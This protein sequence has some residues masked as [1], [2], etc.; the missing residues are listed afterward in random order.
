[1]DGNDAVYGSNGYMV[2]SLAGLTL[3]KSNA[4]GTVTETGTVGL[5]LGATGI[6]KDGNGAVWASAK[7]TTKNV[8]VL[9]GKQPNAAN[10]PVNDYDVLKLTSTKLVLAFPEPGSGSGGTAWFWMF[11]VAD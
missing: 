5:D 3:K 1:M 9:C 6:K 11:R 4:A 8:S 7:M 2:F 10:A